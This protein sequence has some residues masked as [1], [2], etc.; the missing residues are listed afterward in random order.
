MNNYSEI[1]ESQ[2]GTEGWIDIPQSLVMTNMI[3]SH[4]MPGKIVVKQEGDFNTTSQ[5]W[6]SKD[7]AVTLV[8]NRDEKKAA[9][10]FVYFDDGMSLD[11][12]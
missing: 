6:L 5:L 3:P 7:N 11:Q 10:G 12:P 8:V 2:G 4:L 1:I 9:T